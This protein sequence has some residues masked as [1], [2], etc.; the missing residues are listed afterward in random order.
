LL[1]DE[2]KDLNLRTVVGP[3]IGYQVWD[4]PNK[5]LGLEAGVSYFSEDRIEAEDNQWITGRLAGNLMWKLFEPISFTDYLVIYPSFE[6]FG[7]YQL[8]NEAALISPLTSG[9]SLKLTNIVEHDSN[10]PVDVE[11]S[12][13]YWLLGLA[14]DF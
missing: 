12:D 3:G 9:W 4:N 5:S 6:D 10:P 13:I 8:R 11:K 14:Y 7:E 1:S 2:F